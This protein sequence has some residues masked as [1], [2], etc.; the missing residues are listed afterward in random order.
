MGLL[1]G[2]GCFTNN[3]SIPSITLKLHERDP[4]PIEAVRALLGGTVY[5]PYNHVGRSYRIL[6]IRKTDEIIRATK[7]CMKHMPE[8]HKRTQMIEW[9][10]NHGLLI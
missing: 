10:T 9:I 7:I 4:L 6:L 1:V 3:G 5:G 2:E 8:S